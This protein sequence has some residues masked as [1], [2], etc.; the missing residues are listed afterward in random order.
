M[1]QETVFHMRT[2]TSVVRVNN[3]DVDKLMVDEDDDFIIDDMGSGS[4]WEL[5]PIPV[6]LSGKASEGQRRDS[7]VE[8]A[9]E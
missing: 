8:V 9:E 6:I 4:E 5:Q 3:D 1:M 7:A 2:Q